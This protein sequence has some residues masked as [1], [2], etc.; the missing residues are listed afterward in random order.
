MANKLSDVIV[1]PIDRA[2]EWFETHPSIL[3]IEIDFYRKSI[4]T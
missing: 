2:I 3:I 4:F 1:D